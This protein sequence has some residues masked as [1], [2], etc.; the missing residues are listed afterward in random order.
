MLKLIVFDCDGVMFS[1]KEANRIYYNSL[2]DHFGCPPMDD[3]EADFVHSRNVLD[4]VH[5]IFRN[6]NQVNSQEVTSYRE[7]LDYTP[8]LRYMEMEPDLLEFLNLI[9]PQYNTAISTNRTT[10]MDNVLDTFELRPWFDMVVTASDVENPKPAPDALNKIMDHFKVKANEIIYI[11]DSE[12]DQGHCESV[13]VDLI[14]FKNP[15]LHAKY[16]VENFMTIADL[17]PLKKQ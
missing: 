16:Y 9:K 10:T 3:N 6:H 8:F 17:P 15:N 5:H 4:S 13:G 1:S 2:L 12:V 7:Q 11:G 14:A